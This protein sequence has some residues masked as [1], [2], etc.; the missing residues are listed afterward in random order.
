MFTRLTYFFIHTYSLMHCAAR[1]GPCVKQRPHTTRTTELHLARV[2]AF[3]LLL[4]LDKK[5]WG[6]LCFPVPGDFFRL[7]L[8]LLERLWRL[9]IF[10]SEREKRMGWTPSGLLGLL[11][12]LLLPFS[13]SGSD[14]GYLLREG[15]VESTLHL[16]LDYL[17]TARILRYS[18]DN[19]FKF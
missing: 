14:T 7:S 6:W 17:S 1:H 8:L 12:F 19:W 2:P 15:K 5:L 16:D 18:P 3:S 13:L 9:I 4:D 11:F 10:F